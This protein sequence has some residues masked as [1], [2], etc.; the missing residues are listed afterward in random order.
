MAGQWWC[1]PLFPALGRQRQEDFWVRGHPSLQ[2]EFQDSQGGLHRETLSRKTKPNQTKPN[3][4]HAINV[5]FFLSSQTL[6][7]C[8]NHFFFFGLFHFMYIG[9]L[10]ACIC[11]WGGRDALKIQKRSSDLLESELE[12]IEFQCGCWEWNPVLSKSNQQPVFFTTEPYLQPSF[13]LF[14]LFWDSVS[15]CSTVWSGTTHHV[16]QAGFEHC[17]RFLWVMCHRSQRTTFSLPTT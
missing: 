15:L 13:Y 3:Q 5:S 6:R 16:G 17:I 11:I 9:I 1:T 8:S 4:K 2:S 14:I 10:P 7:L 12:K